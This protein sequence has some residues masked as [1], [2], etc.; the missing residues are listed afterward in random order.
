MLFG[1]IQQ[2]VVFVISVGAFVFEAW[3]LIDALR[4]SNSAYEAA[5]KQTRTLW[6]ALLGA[7]TVI[8]FLGLPYPLGVPL[9][10][11]LGFLGIAAIVA[12]AVYAFGVRPALHST[13]RR[14]PQTRNKRG[15]W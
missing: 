15:G 11:A 9:A 4:Y 13:G 5:G 10:S 6:G 14:P 12:A 8:G 2:G 1:T 3:A 7:A